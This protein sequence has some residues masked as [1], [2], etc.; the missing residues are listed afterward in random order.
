MIESGNG[1][2]PHPTVYMIFPRQTRA[3]GKSSAPAPAGSI[4]GGIAPCTI[5]TATST[6]KTISTITATAI[7]ASSPRRRPVQDLKPHK[8][9]KARPPLGEDH[10]HRPRGSDCERRVRLRRRDARKPRELR[11]HDHHAEQPH[12]LGRQRSR[13]WTARR[14]MSPAEV[15]ASTVNS[16]VCINCSAVAHEHL[17]PVRRSPRPPAAASSYTADGYIVTNQHVVSRRV[18]APSTSRSITATPIAATRGGQRQRLRC[19][20]AEGRRE[21]SDTAVTLGEFHRTST[22]ATRCWPSATRWVS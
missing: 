4:E 9:K 14:P 10:G 20:R 7:P 16:V 8:E 13:R 18:E 5:T 1:K 19:G 2:A 6:T 17:R 15:Y 12:R 21:G 3:A 11:Q 22:W